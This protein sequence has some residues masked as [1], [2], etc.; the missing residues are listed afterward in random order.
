VLTDEARLAVVLTSVYDNLFA[1]E[2]QLR[3]PDIM[4]SHGIT[5]RLSLILSQ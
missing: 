4:K 5:P 2:R 3:I 1:P